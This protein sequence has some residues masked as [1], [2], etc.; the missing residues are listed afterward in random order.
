MHAQYTF[1]SLP[2]QADEK[3]LAGRRYLDEPW[4]AQRLA[5]EHARASL[6]QLAQDEQLPLPM[7]EAC[8]R[9]FRRLGQFMEAL[10]PQPP[11]APPP[12]P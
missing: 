5:L 1:P 6:R 10:R 11:A 7:R 8:A 12:E 4:L 9:M 3:A 2:G